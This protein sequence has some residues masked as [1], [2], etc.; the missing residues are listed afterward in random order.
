MS[1]WDYATQVPTAAWRNAMTVPRNVFLLDV[2][3]KPYLASLPS[4][5]LMGLAGRKVK[6]KRI[7]VDSS[8]NLS[9]T[10]KDDG[11]RYVLKIRGAADQSVAFVFSDASGEQ[12]VFGYNNIKQEFYIDRSGSGK[13]DFHPGFGGIYT[14]P[15]VGK[16][17]E[18]DLQFVVDRSSIEVFADGGLTVMSAVFFSKE[19]LTKVRVNT[20]DRWVI[21]ELDYTALASIW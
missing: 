3:N 8:A 11:G 10:L 7:V 15:R 12:M 18:L 14:A 5:E 6:T 1:N 17:K 21:K 20:T 16:E 9:S 13:T 2:N 4:P 19:P